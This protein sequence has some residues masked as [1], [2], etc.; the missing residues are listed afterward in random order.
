M[1]YVRSR[2]IR[3]RRTR[4]YQPKRF[5]SV[6]TR[7]R[8]SYTGY[9]ASTSRYRRR[10]GRS[11]RR[12]RGHNWTGYARKAGTWAGAANNALHLAKTVYSLINP[13]FKYVENNT[14]ANTF[15]NTAPQINF[16]T[17]IGQGVT[18]TTRTGN[19]VLLKYIRCAFN[20]RYNTSSAPTTL[21]ITIVTVQDGTAPVG[22][23]IYENTASG[24]QVVISGWK[25]NSAIAYKVYY[26]K[27]F[28]V[29]QYNPQRVFTTDIRAR[30]HHHI[31]YTGPS[32][33]DTG[34]GNFWAITT[35]DQT[36]SGNSIALSQAYRIVYLDN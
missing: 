36:G 23:D 25:K 1:P 19:S 33:T 13:E 29:D 8:S 16:I 35:V 21:R 28:H 22:T 6:S 32:P 4:K 18:S 3:Y 14:Y 27:I 17:S 34:P 15:A 9:R 24:T 26:D 7:S 11:A 30:G 5:R 31:K 12:G 2:F 20:I 10:P